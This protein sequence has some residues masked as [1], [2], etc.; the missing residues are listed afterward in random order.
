MTLD[1]DDVLP[2]IGGWGKYQKLLFWLICVPAALPCAF[3]G[4]VQVF[5][6]AIPPHWCHVPELAGFPLEAQKNLS[7]PYEEQLGELVP[8]QCNMYD[9]DYVQLVRENVTWVANVSWPKVPCTR[10]WRYEHKLY[11]ETVTTEMD[12]V[13]DKNWIGMMTYTVY[14]FGNLC[15]NFIFG[16]L[17]DWLGRKKA[18]FICLTVETVFGIATAFAPELISYTVFRFMV[19]LT[20]PQIFVIPFVIGIELVGPERR[21]FTTIMQCVSYSSG[22]LVLAGVAYL[23]R[24]WRNLALA[25][26]IPFILMYGYWWFLP[27]SARWLLSKNRIDEAE[28]IVQK[29]AKVNGMTVPPELIRKLMKEQEKGELGQLLPGKARTYT[30]LDL[31]RTPNLRKKTVLVSFIWL[32]NVIVYVGLSIYIPILGESD[33]V[34]FALSSAVELLSY[35]ILFCVIDRWGRRWPLCISMMLGGVACIATVLVPSGYLEP[36]IILAL[37]G[38]FGAGT[39]FTLMYLFS[40]EI[41]PTVLRGI[42]IGFSELVGSVGGVATPFI[43][44]LGYQY[45]DLPAFI[46]GTVTLVASVLAMA[47]PETLNQKLPETVEEA[48]EFGKNQPFCFCCARRK[49]SMDDVARNDEDLAAAKSSDETENL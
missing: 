49:P 33:Y 7:L 9:I 26:S 35:P 15:G 11:D 8:S 45:R 12:L 32:V 37:V 10:G 39:S 17:Q 22:L 20:V 29:A 25:T 6:N 4:F 13:C 36:T 31:F 16:F 41:F 47:L 42:G 48:E 3:H 46:M 38:K 28:A 43:V 40:G 21:G 34:N 27:E 30:L 24:D 19:G 23:V 18:F 14:S 5:M 1:F 2:H 44:Y